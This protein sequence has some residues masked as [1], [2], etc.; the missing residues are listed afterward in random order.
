MANGQQPTSGLTRGPDGN[1]YGMALY[2]GQTNNGTLF[3]LTP[4]G[5][6]TPLSSVGGQTRLLYSGWKLFRN[7]SDN[8]LSRNDGG[9][10]RKLACL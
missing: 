10:R 5:T 4:N 7:Y 6:I 3:R 1:F 9:Y 8:Y 2:G